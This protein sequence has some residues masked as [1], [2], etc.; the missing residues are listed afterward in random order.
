[1]TYAGRKYIEITF[2]M[3]TLE[4]RDEAIQEQLE[5]IRKLKQTVNDLKQKLDARNR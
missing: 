5:E 3:K 4:M 2:Y 1:M